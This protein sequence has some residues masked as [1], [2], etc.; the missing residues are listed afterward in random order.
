MDRHSKIDLPSLSS[1][2][3]TRQLPFRSDD[4][5]FEEGFIEDRQ[6]RL[7][8]FINNIAGHPLAQNQ[9][10]LHMFL[11]EPNIDRDKTYGERDIVP[12]KIRNA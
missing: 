8:V 5:T 11:L 9:I 6:S 1:K 7:E 12:G 10:C 4:G 2:A 3:I